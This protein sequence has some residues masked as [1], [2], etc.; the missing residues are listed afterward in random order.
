MHAIQN[1][2]QYKNHQIYFWLNILVKFL[3]NISVMSDW[4]YFAKCILHSYS[5]NKW[6][7]A[8]CKLLCYNVM[9]KIK[10]P[11]KI[12]VKWDIIWNKTKHSS[13]RVYAGKTWQTKALSAFNPTGGQHCSNHICFCTPTRCQLK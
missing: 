2:K 8:F 7:I 3:K 12:F 13:S 5:P 9:Y 11:E 1:W 4:K 10:S 6:L